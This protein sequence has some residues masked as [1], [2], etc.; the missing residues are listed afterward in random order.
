MCPRNFKIALALRWLCFGFQFSV[1]IQHMKE[2]LIF[3][4]EIKRR[5]HRIL[6]GKYVPLRSSRAPQEALAAG[7][8]V[9]GQIWRC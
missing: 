3:T 7:L 9:L 4:G 1:L 6:F 2:P 5:I 8:P